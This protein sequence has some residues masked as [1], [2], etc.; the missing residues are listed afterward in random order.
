MLILLMLA[1]LVLGVYPG[2]FITWAQ[3]AGLMS[4]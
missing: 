3:G 2:P 4:P 1:M